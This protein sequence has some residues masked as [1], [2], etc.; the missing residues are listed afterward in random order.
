MTEAET[1]TD[2][3]GRDRE[4]VDHKTQGGRRAESRELEVN[5]GTE[6]APPLRPGW[7][8]KPR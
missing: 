2:R 7:K 1:E 6:S 8:P 3:T 4:E 5:G